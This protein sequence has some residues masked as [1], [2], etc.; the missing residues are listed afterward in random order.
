MLARDGISRP[1]R[2]VTCVIAG[3]EKRSGVRAGGEGV[4]L[5]CAKSPVF[6]RVSTIPPR[7]IPPDI[8]PVVQCWSARI[9]SAQCAVDHVDKPSVGWLSRGSVPA[10]TVVRL[11]PLLWLP[12]FHQHNQKEHY[13]QE[14]FTISLDRRAVADE[15][16][17]ERALCRVAGRIASSCQSG[18]IWNDRHELIGSWELSHTVCAVSNDV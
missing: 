5:K 2:P 4:R 7:M 17:L 6:M 13:M 3:T 15:S 8:P 12:A 9:P 14:T 1:S 18:P 11:C 16:E 10:L